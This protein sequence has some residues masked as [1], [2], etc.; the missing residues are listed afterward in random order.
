MT[1]AQA[2]RTAPVT[3][4]ASTPALDRDKRPPIIIRRVEVDL[5]LI[6]I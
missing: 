4:A 1:A 2:A 3:T 5:S 6:H